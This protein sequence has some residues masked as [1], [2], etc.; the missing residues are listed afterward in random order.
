[1]TWQEAIRRAEAL[2]VPHKLE[3]YEYAMTVIDMGMDYLAFCERHFAEQVAGVAGPDASPDL[4]VCVFGVHMARY[5][6]DRREVPA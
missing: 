3:G 5:I 4:L 6:A 2:D 1:M